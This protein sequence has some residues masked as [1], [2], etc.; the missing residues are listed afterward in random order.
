MSLL[1]GG[2]LLEGL[3]FIGASVLCFLRALERT[4]GRLATVFRTA[5]RANKGPSKSMLM[6]QDLTHL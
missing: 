3:T 6:P 2:G 5:S 4:P 1:L